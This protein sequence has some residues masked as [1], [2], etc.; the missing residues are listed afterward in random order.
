M[1]KTGPAPSVMFLAV[2]I[3]MWKS[4]PD[5]TP[6]ESEPQINVSFSDSEIVV[7]GLTIYNTT[8][9]IT[10]ITS[11]ITIVLV[12]FLPPY[13]GFTLHYQYF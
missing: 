13:P 11:I 4:L 7:P 5:M 2:A 9:T 3:K 10:M 6:M 12:Q 8:L 1:H